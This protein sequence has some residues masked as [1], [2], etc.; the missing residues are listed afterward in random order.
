MKTLNR[1]KLIF[2]SIL[3]STLLLVGCNEEST[4]IS[5]ELVFLEK[6]NE[7]GRPLLVFESIEDKK[8]YSIEFTNWEYDNTQYENGE[9]LEVDTRQEKELG[10]IGR[11][12]LELLFDFVQTTDFEV[13]INEEWHHLFEMINYTKTK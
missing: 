13:Y 11:G 6:T 12:L 10:V 1:G 7:Y 8:Y 2:F 5:K 4:N 3:F 9:I